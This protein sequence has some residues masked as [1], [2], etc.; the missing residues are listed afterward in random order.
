VALAAHQAAN[1]GEWDLAEELCDIATS[2]GSTTNS[3]RES[4][5]MP[6]DLLAALTR[7]QILSSIGAW[8]DGAHWAMQTAELSRA[9]GLAG[10]VAMN[11]GGA[12]AAMTYGGEDA[13]AVPVATEG[14]DLA[15]AAQMPRALMYNLHVLAV[16]LADLEPDRARELFD[17]AL[18]LYESVGYESPMELVGIT[19][20]AARLADW[21]Q[22]ARLVA[23]TIRRL[24]WLGHR[25]WLVGMF[26][27]SAWVLA[28]TDPEAA[29]VIQ[30]AARTFA[31]EATTSSSTDP[32]PQR[33]VSG[34]DYFAVTRRQTARKLADT[35]GDDRRR[36]LKQQG[37]S[38]HADDAVTYALA[39][40]EKFSALTKR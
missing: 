19:M 5:V 16:A 30:G 3:R 18:E 7:G 37:A 23:T 20:A 22:T 31:Q 25:P 24:H 27:V 40:L 26:N 15:R 29:A 12:A 34:T 35:L 10:V 9:Y 2:I 8:S 14:L 4:G 11:L 13:A 38:M 33:A 39:H 6:P 28:D 36:D 21:D 17:E 32:K 1:R